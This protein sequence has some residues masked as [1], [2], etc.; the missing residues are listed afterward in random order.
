MEKQ[1]ARR[2]G[3]AG[4]TRAAECADLDRELRELVAALSPDDDVPY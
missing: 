1:P 4:G 2:T 3:K